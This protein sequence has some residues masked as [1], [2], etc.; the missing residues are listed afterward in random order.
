MKRLICRCSDSPVVVGIKLVIALKLLLV[1]V[2]RKGRSQLDVV[3]V[4]ST[5]F[6]SRSTAGP[7][8]RPL[9]AVRIDGRE[10][11]DVRGVHEPGDDGVPAVLLQEVESKVEE[12]LPAGGLV[13]CNVGDQPDEGLEVVLAASDVPGDPHTQQRGLSAAHTDRK[14]HGK[15]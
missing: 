7:F 11:S 14:R 12:K 1:S 2:C 4:N 3:G 9:K 5:H 10:N 15:I 8:A 6:V 13:P